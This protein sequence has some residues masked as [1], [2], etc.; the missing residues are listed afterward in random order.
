MI[1]GVVGEIRWGDGAGAYRAAAINGYRVT[2]ADKHRQRWTLSGTVVL[3]DSFKMAQRPLYF[4]AKLRGGHEWR[5]P[6][7]RLDVQ[8]QNGFPILTAEL[9]SEVS[10]VSEVSDGTIR[11]T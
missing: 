3:S 5:W 9:G 7:V 1:R 2:P 11:S 10:D 4:V 8:V 6:I